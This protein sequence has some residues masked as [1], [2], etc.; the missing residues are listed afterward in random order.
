LVDAVFTFGHNAFK[1]LGS[2]G[3]KHYARRHFK[4][5]RYPNSGVW[6]DEFSQEFTAFAQRQVGQVSTFAKQEIKNEIVDARSLGAKVLKQ[7]KVRSARVIETDN[8]AIHNRSI[9]QIGQRFDEVRV[10]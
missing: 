3:G 2:H 8:L 6:F 1:L 10:L 7:I 9:G 5:L 4:L